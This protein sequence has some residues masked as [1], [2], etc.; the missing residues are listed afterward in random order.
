MYLISKDGASEWHFSLQIAGTIN[1]VRS[2]EVKI[3]S[4]WEQATRKDYNYWELSKGAAGSTPD[5][6]VTCSNNVQVVVPQVKISSSN[7]VTSN[8]NC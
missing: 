4:T 8:I 6:R 7:V 3:G 5:V 1:P 2:V